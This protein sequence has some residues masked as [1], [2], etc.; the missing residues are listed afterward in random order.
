MS[1][2]KSYFGHNIGA[3]GIVELIACLATLPDNRVLPTLNFSHA[4]PNCDLD[5]VPNEFRDRKVNIFMKNNYAFGG[6]N[7][8]MI[9]SMEP[10]SIPVST[11]DS[12]RVAISGVGAVSAIGHTLNQ[13][14][15]NIWAQDHHVEL[16]SVTFP[17]DTLE[18]AK[19]LLAVLDESNQFAE[20]FDEEYS[21]S[22]ATLPETESNFKTFRVSGLE[23]RKHL[24]R[25]DQ[26]KA[27][28]GG[29]FALI[30]LTEAL[31]Q[32][33]RKIKRDGDELGMIMGMSRGPQETTYKY[34]Q[35]LK[36]DPRKVRTS[37]FPG[38]LMNAI[39]TFCGIS[40]GIKGYTTTLATG[41]KLGA[42][43]ADLR[44]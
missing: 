16:G 17:D 9:L 25:F 6:N 11:Y 27:T 30:A 40:E 18:E 29:T 26:R 24:R 3:A 42:G 32:A 15:E 2:T 12:K 38:S 19:E 7:C 8:C 20:L 1:S 44:L 5:Y 4:R 41:G 13:V 36:P 37:E 28:R 14:L 23:P 39:P 35:S 31:E 10:A 34:L 22:E 43:R 21:F 33:K